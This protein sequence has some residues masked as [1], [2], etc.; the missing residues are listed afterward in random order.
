[1][2]TLHWEGER[3]F[4]L[5]LIRL[6][7][8]GAVKV[9]ERNDFGAKNVETMLAL[10]TLVTRHK[11]NITSIYTHK[12]SPAARKHSTHDSYVKW[13]CDGT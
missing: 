1:M 7:V 2:W 4:R 9:S 11:S 13:R 3:L 8:V 5:T 12:F 10:M 6:K